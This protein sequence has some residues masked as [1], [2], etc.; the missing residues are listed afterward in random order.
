[1]G[2]PAGGAAPDR[3]ARF[4]FAAVLFLTSGGVR[5]GVL[6]GESPTPSNLQV[7]GRGEGLPVNAVLSLAQSRT[8]DI[9]IGTANGLVR[10]DGERFRTLDRRTAPVLKH[11]DIEA[12]AEDDSGAIWIGTL[13]G[14]N[15]LRGGVMMA[16][17]LAE[18]EPC[19][20]SL[21]AHR[22]V[23]W[24]GTERG[25]YRIDPARPR[26]VGFI[27]SGRVRAVAAALDGSILVG[28]EEGLRRL[29]PGGLLPYGAPAEALGRILSIL[30]ERDGSLWLGTSHG[31]YSL[32]HGVATRAED[33]GR[34]TVIRTI[35][36]TRAGTIWVGA[37][38]GLFRLENG[39]P[40]LASPSLANEV[41]P[42]L[43]EDRDGDLWIATVSSGLVRIGQDP[44]LTVDFGNLLPD[45]SVWALEADA[46]GRI[47]FGTAK[48]RFGLVV[49]G[50]G[51]LNVV[52]QL[53]APITAIAA[54]PG[55]GTLLVST[56]GHGAYRYDPERETWKSAGLPPDLVVLALSRDTRGGMWAGTIGGVLHLKAGKIEDLKADKSLPSNIVTSVHED[57]SGRLWIGFSERGLAEWKDGALRLWTVREGLAHNSVIAIAEGAD[58]E[59]WIATAGGLTRIRDGIAQS[60]PSWLVSQIVESVIDDGRGHLWLGTGRGILRIAKSA[61]DSGRSAPAEGDILELGHSAGMRS[62]ACSTGNASVVRT[63]DGRIWFG[64]QSGLARVDPDHLTLPAVAPAVRIEELIRDGKSFRPRPAW[65]VPSGPGALAIGYTAPSFRAAENL[66]FEYRMAGIDRDWVRAGNRRTAYYT[67]LPPGKYDFTVRV[68]EGNGPLA[69]APARQRIVVEPR[70]FETAWFAGGVAASVAGMLL[71]AHRFRVNHVSEALRLKSALERAQLSALREQLRPHFLFNTLNTV[72]PLIRHAPDAAETMIVELSDL[73]RASLRTEPSQ[74]VPLEEELRT[75][76]QYFRIAGLR[77]RERFSLAVQIAPEVE[78]ALVPSFLLQPI[79]ENAIR[80]G[81]EKSS[82]RVEVRMFAWAAGNSLRIEMSN[83]AVDRQEGSPPEKSSGIGLEN[84]RRRL[85]WLFGESAR[86]ELVVRERGARTTIVMPLLFAPA[87][88]D[89]AEHPESLRESVGGG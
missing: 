87:T 7:W 49:P 58:G 32:S 26:T 13:G 59:T 44:V 80:H 57:R 40:R 4:V 71:L 14:L 46:R 73:L 84:T 50:S 24:V 37:R 77:F 27:P 52:R 28:T 72:L 38:E 74:L 78:Q 35:L 76:R 86:L 42:A 34:P 66:R 65:S 48:G 85:S 75:M 20:L 23:V 41:V 39:R 45:Q 15:V 51:T 25:L 5:A 82:G 11:D 18:N 60:A 83:D 30:P 43:L 61:M 2:I 88:P 53:D 33:N 67:N 56:F 70:W 81:V 6:A 29:G 54:E 55:A 62:A 17:R 68:R 79:A 69:G 12:L 3:A 21:F 64:T 10:F 89:R 22:G 9:W 31:V 1:M 36:R 63:P 8:G 19:I 47:W 16:Y